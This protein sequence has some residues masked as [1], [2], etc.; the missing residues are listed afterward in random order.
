MTN[1]DIPDSFSITDAFAALEEAEWIRL[2]RADGIS[3][4]PEKMDETDKTMLRNRFK[5]EPTNFY[6]LRYKDNDIDLGGVVITF[7]DHS[8]TFAISKKKRFDKKTLT[9]LS[10]KK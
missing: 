3:V 10:L 7:D 9:S 1:F 2:L 6:R 8:I 5:K 4:T